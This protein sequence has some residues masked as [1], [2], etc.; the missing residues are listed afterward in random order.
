MISLVITT[1]NN[2]DIIDFYINESSKRGVNLCIIGDK[3]SKK[4]NNDNFISIADQYELEMNITKMIPENHYS[5]KN[6]GYILSKNS[7]I[8]IE[9]DDDNIPYENFWDIPK[10][11]NF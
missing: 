8:I 7:E 4:I 11:E 1:I 5:R 2:N 6:I 9:T 3:K 10:L